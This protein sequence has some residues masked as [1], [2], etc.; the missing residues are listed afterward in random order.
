MAGMEVDRLDVKPIE[1]YTCSPSTYLKDDFN[2][3]NISEI[4]YF[5]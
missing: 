1:M 5:R 3:V 4:H 2:L